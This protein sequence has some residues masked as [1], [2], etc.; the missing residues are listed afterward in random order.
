M[1]PSLGFGLWL[2]WLGWPGLAWLGWA[3]TII[4]KW[5]KLKQCTDLSKS[6]TLGSQM[7]NA[8]LFKL[9]PEVKDQKFYEM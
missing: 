9:V 5:V 4:D 3:V 2:G 6:F 7:P 8:F 1:S